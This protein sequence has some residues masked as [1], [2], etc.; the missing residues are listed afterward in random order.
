[1]YRYLISLTMMCLLGCASIISGTSQTIIVSTEPPGASCH[2]LQGGRAVGTVSSTPGG[3]LAP[4]TRHNLRLNCKKDGYAD[5]SGSISSG[6]EPWVLG[7]LLLPAFIGFGVDLGTG[8][9]NRYDEA[10]NVALIKATEAPPVEPAPP[11]LRPKG[12]G[13]GW[14]TVDGDIVTNYHVIE[15]ASRIL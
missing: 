9:W 15:G 7:N 2:I 14:F 10:V 11:A 8:A 6:V 5:S 4:K 13:S 1:M 12:S 3:F